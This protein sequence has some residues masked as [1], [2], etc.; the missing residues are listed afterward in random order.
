LDRGEVEFQVK[1][2]RCDGDHEILPRDRLEL[3]ETLVEVASRAMLLLP[4]DKV[5]DVNA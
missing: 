3:N 2:D 1:V 5:V 4:L